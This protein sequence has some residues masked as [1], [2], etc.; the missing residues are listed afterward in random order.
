MASRLGKSTPVE[1][2]GSGLHRPPASGGTKTSRL[3]GQ[4]GASQQIGV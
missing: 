4:C 2:V 3:C 1:S